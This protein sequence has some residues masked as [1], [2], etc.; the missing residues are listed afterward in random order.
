MFFLRGV[1][2]QSRDATSRSDK[3][4]ALRDEYKRRIAGKR[5]SQ[6]VSLLIDELFRVPVLSVPIAR[7]LLGVTHKPARESPQRLIQAN[8]LGA[9]PVT[10]RGTSY[11]LAGELL[12]LTSRPLVA[13]SR[14][15][16]G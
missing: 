6:G 10:V 16:I 5:V 8:I 4:V 3:L 15:T 14:L 13:E 1:T 2:T 9:E 12:A 11:Y 7:E